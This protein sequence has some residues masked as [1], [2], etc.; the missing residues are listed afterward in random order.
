MAQ[1]NVIELT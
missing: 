1:A